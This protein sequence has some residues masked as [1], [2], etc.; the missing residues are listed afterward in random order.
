MSKGIIK[1][2]AI[3]VA[4]AL[5]AAL[6][7]TVLFLSVPLGGRASVFSVTVLYVVGG[8]I[9]AIYLAAAIIFL[10]RWRKDR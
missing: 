7:L 5:L 1:R 6:F 2:I 3:V 10:V 8:V 4:A 9:A